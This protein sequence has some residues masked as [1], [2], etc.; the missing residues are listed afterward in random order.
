M[1]KR[2][3]FCFPGMPIFT[4]L[5]IFAIAN[6]ASAQIQ[7][8]KKATTMKISSTAFGPNGLIP[9]KYTCEGE[10]VSPPLTFA[11]IPAGTKSL[12]LIVDDPDAPDPAHPKI[13]W[14]HWV[15]YNIPTGVSDLAEGALH[16]PEGI[17]FGMTNN[18]KTAYGG[19]CPPIGTHRYFFKLFALDTTLPD[20]KNPTAAQLSETMKN[21]IIARAELIGRYKKSR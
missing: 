17:R 7:S 2:E 5:F 1:K 14:V 8:E 20:L 4:L 19:P 6:P 10:D 21:H 16:F 11:D 15:L 9:T 3:N 13:T 12:A 18:K